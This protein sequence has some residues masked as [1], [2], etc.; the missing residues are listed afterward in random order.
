MLADALRETRAPLCSYTEKDCLGEDET[1]EAAGAALQ[2]DGLK[3]AFLTC[4]LQQDCPVLLALEKAASL[5]K[6]SISCGDLATK[7]DF[8]PFI[9]SLATNTAMKELSLGCRLTGETCEELGA[10]LIS[11]SCLEVL[12]ALCLENVGAIGPAL[13]ANSSLKSLDLHGQH[14][15]HGC[16]RRRRCT[17]PCP[18]CAPVPCARY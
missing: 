9:R 18:P 3:E 11:N 16:G 10:S 4:G 6:V 12:Q 14:S 7:A 5:R 8:G 13:V 2:R 15:R 1:S 17:G